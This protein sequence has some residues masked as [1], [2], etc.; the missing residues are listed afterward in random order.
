MTHNTNENFDREDRDF[1]TEG[2]RV[3]TDE[4]SSAPN[5]NTPEQENQDNSLQN[6]F[7]RDPNEGDSDNNPNR[8]TLDEYSAAKNKPDEDTGLEKA[9]LDTDRQNDDKDPLDYESDDDYE[10]DDLDDVED[11]DLENANLRDAFNDDSINKEEQSD[12]ENKD[13]ATEDKI[14]YSDPELDKQNPNIN[15]PD[16]FRPKRF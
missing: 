13:F 16:P 14:R 11:E 6:D 10:I 7:Y 12:L 15:D 9:A 1:Y 3:S 8:R 4:N 5:K 2:Q